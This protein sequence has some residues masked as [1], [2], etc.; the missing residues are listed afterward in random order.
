MG[1]T[2]TISKQKSTVPIAFPHDGPIFHWLSKDTHLVGSCCF[3]DRPNVPLESADRWALQILQCCDDK[4]SSSSA[5]SSEFPPVSMDEDDLLL[6]PILNFCRNLRKPTTT[7]KEQLNE[8]QQFRNKLVEYSRKQE[9]KNKTTALW[10]SESSVWGIYRI[11]LEWSL[12]YQT[13]L[14]FQRAIQSF[15]KTIRQMQESSIDPTNDTIISQT[16]LRSIVSPLATNPWHDPL[17]SLDVAV[18]NSQLLEILRKPPLL[19]P[20]LQ[21]LVQSPPI[22]TTLQQGE[23]VGRLQQQDSIEMQ[24][25]MEEALQLCSSLKTLLVGLDVEEKP[26]NDD[27]ND[28]DTATLAAL[29]PLVRQLQ[30]FVQV[31]LSASTLPS[32]GFNTLGILFGKLLCWG[33]SLNSK[34]ELE[35]TTEARKRLARSCVECIA[36]LEEGGDTTLSPLA[37]L[38]VVQGIAATIPSD[39]LTCDLVNSNPPSIPLHVCWTYSLH[40]G[41]H[42]TDPLVRWA[43]LKGLSTLMSRWNQQQ[44]QQQQQALLDG[45]TIDETDETTE[46]QQKDDSVSLLIDETL[47]LVFESWEN[48][49]LRKMGTAIPGLFKAIVQTLSQQHRHDVF[50]QVLNQPVNRKGRYLAIEILLPYMNITNMNNSDGLTIDGKTAL[51]IESFLEGVGDQGPN[52]G[53]IADLWIKILQF[54]WEVLSRTNDRV[55]DKIQPAAYDSWKKY[56]IPSL[57]RT[58]LQQSLVRRKQVLAFCVPRLVE[59]MRSENLLKDRVPDAFSSLM[60]AVE[61]FKDSCPS[62]CRLWALLKLSCF[63]CTM[64]IAD[65]TLEH[66]ITISLPMQ[67]FQDAL[68]HSA[69]EI[70]IAAYSAMEPVASAHAGS[71]SILEEIKMWK[72]A[73]RFSIKSNDSKEYR[74]SLLQYLCLFLDRLS[75]WDDKNFKQTDEKLENLLDFSI[76]FL[77]RDIFHSKGAYPGTVAD[78]ESTSIAILD[79]LLTFSMQDASFSYDNV[80]PQNGTMFNRKRSAKE[81]DANVETVMVLL[82][83]DVF[84]NLFAFLHSMWDQTRKT[85]YKLLIK[86]LLGAQMK[87]LQLPQGFCSKFQ[88]DFLLARGIHLASSPRSREAD[89]G[90]RMLAFIY[91]SLPNRSEKEEYLAVITDLLRQRIDSM[92]RTL[93]NLL[94]GDVSSSCGSFLPLAHGLVH[95]CRLCLDQEKTGRKLHVPLDASTDKTACGAMLELFYQG[96]QLSLSVVADMREGESIDGVDDDEI[97]VCTVHGDSTP[98]NVNTGAIGANGTFSSVKATDEAERIVRLATQRVVIGTWL[99]T[100]EA[101]AAVSS[102]LTHPMYAASAEQFSTAGQLL[103]STLIS[104]KHSGAAFAARDALQQIS[105]FC[106]SPSASSEIRGYPI[107]WS[108]RLLD[109]ISLTERVRNSTLRRS[110]GYALGFMAI[111]RAEAQSNATSSRTSKVTLERLLALSLPPQES[112]DVAFAKLGID[113]IQVSVLSQDNYE[114]RCRIHALN[115]LRMLILDAPLSKFVSCIAGDCIVSAI[116]GYDDTSWSIRN[117]STMVFAATML[118]VVDADKNASN[119]DKT[120]STAITIT[121]LFRRYPSLSEFL[122]STLRYCVTEMESHGKIEPRLYPVLSMFSRIQS[123]LEADPSASVTIDF[124]PSF[125]RCLG[126]RDYYIRHAA[127]RALSNACPL[128]ERP[129][130]ICKIANWLNASL[131]QPKPDWNKVHGFLLASKALYG[132]ADEVTLDSLH[133]FLLKISQGKAPPPCQ[134]TA[135]SILML[136]CSTAPEAERI[137]LDVIDYSD[138]GSADGASHL[139]STASKV[140]CQ[141]AA[142]NVFFAEDADMLSEGISTLQKLFSCPL[143]DVRLHS[144]KCFKKGIYEKLEGIQLRLNENASNP[145]LP[146]ELILRRLF[147]VLLECTLAESNLDEELSVLGTHIPTLRRLSR[148]L[149][150]TLACNAVDISSGEADI[151]WALSCKMIERDF[152]CATERTDDLNVLPLL[153][154]GETTGANLISSNGVEML[155]IAA[156]VGSSPV[157][158]RLNKLLKVIDLMNNPFV[159]WRCRYSAV[160]AVERFCRFAGASNYDGKF[161]RP[162]VIKYILSFLQDSD[163]DV[164]GVASR[165]ASEFCG[166]LSGKDGNLLPE[167]TLVQFFSC[168]FDNFAGT[169]AG[170]ASTDVPTEALMSIIIDNCDDLISSMQRV[171]AEFRHSS[172]GYFASSVSSDDVLV[173]DDVARKIFE[174]EDPN[175][176]QERVMVNQLAIRSLFDLMARSDT[177]K[178]Y[179]NGKQ[180]KLLDQCKEA[181]ALLTDCLDAG[182]LVHDLSHSPMVFPSLSSL[183]TCTAVICQFSESVES[184]QAIRDMSIP[185]V[186]NS[187]YLHPNILDALQ[188]IRQNE[189]SKESLHRLLFLL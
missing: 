86:L 134:S 80:F 173:N 13:Q 181:L 107:D 182:G 26:E 31:L 165:A 90:S 179:S 22:L 61:R 103:L 50:H 8:L 39:S 125:V 35:E 83:D 93:R 110:T 33:I 167:W 111:M 73:L 130:V 34:C 5:S 60:E 140:L 119:S 186:G 40:A 188:V 69:P 127:A 136:S 105:S 12:S 23:T 135:L 172:Q 38:S 131:E 82:N 28:D 108:A 132:A 154:E 158:S 84:S 37:R 117:S 143:L 48:P 160:L 71:S 3:N 25:Q 157:H 153:G 155:A 88:R 147:V 180:R 98:L 10:S 145:Y 183:V 18:N 30:D 184:I 78:K 187:R 64:N 161:A 46:D 170:A 41:R 55:L 45:D 81:N 62:E 166:G 137:C 142:S 27:D 66:Q 72:M 164:R 178:L 54:M 85:S 29:L 17:Y 159:S 68:I 43:A 2:K 56:W 76:D 7:A 14:P 121:E 104:L 102:L 47:G 113:T 138:D 168:A 171:L 87:K 116:L 114:A 141:V 148:C 42:S 91:A 185:L 65:P 4:P 19:V 70:R 52:A 16:I 75:I 59:F 177:K 115:V 53:A 92:K 100:K 118:R 152:G 109:E 9:N 149:L 162:L 24:R 123:V 139:F 44:Q 126:C 112:I 1:R 67:V 129:K 63:A 150:E 156:T 77:I 101:C 58:I 175:P 128:S 169:S 106:F 51:P 99:L 6:E 89:T 120:S 11:L 122:S 151:M 32:E 124:L 163:P 95:A 133:T 176:F 97:E 20:C 189:M 174:D 94:S 36:S 15:L 79:C 21:F 146:S 49:P 57:C 96:L 74:S 144:V